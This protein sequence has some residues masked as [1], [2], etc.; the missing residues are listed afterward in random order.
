MGLTNEA[1][2]LHDRTTR[3][4]LDAGAIRQCPHRE[5]VFVT[6]LDRDASRCAYRLGAAMVADGAVDANEEAMASA[7]AWALSAV[8]LKC[9]LCE[10]DRK[11]ERAMRFELTTPTLARLCSTPELRPLGCA[12]N[13][14][15]PAGVS[16]GLALRRAGYGA[17]PGQMQQENESMQRA[18]GH[19]ESAVRAPITT[20][21]AD[22]ITGLQDRT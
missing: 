16:A 21:N 9:P 18:G 8:V 7:V 20:E 12:G 10:V 11:L 22:K 4:R 2:T 5:G 19:C 6:A 14:S 3:G 13:L 15:T 17:T 1:E